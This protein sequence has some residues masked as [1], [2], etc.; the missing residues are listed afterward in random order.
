M[1]TLLPEGLVCAGEAKKC[2]YRA[3][4]ELYTDI[5]SLY[6]GSARRNELSH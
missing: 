3:T 2:L 5:F 1:K 4:D 6:F